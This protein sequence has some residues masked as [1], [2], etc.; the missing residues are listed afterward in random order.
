MAY[1]LA[2]TDPET[3]SIDQF[4]REVST[5]WDGVS[6]PQAVRAIQQM[7]PGDRVFIYHS[8]AQP[9]V[10]GLAEVISEPPRPRETQIGSGRLQVSAALRSA[11]VV[12]RDQGIEI[13]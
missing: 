10:V 5:T 4:E 3:Y 1:F 8:V 12:G 2:K 6:N 9:A 13:V 7:R 11:N